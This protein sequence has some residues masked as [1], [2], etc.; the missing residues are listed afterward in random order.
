MLLTAASKSILTGRIDIGRGYK[1]K[2]YV[3]FSYWSREIEKREKKEIDRERK[4]A[5]E[6]KNRKQNCD[7]DNWLII[8][9]IHIK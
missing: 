1:G 4:I 3:I 8:I 6:N 7:N 5:E 9:L 2:Y